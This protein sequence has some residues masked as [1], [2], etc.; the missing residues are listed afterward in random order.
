MD[1]VTIVGLEFG[2]A[3]FP[4]S[5]RHGGW[6]HCYSQKAVAG[7]SVCIFRGPAALCSGD[8]GLCYSTLLGP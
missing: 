3:G 8:G 6:R 7:P 4:G 5:R 1:Q 2:K